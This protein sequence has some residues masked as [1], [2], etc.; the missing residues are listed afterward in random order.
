MH[1]CLR[2]FRPTRFTK[3][4]Y[5]ATSRKLNARMR[6]GI[7]VALSVETDDVLAQMGVEEMSADT[8]I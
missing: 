5:R 6:R 8:P 2:N 1:P 3:A 4:R 7:H